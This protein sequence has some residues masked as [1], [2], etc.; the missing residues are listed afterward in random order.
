MRNLSRV[1]LAALAVVAMLTGCVRSEPIHPPRSTSTPT[2]SAEPLF[3]SDAEALAAATAAYA[4]YLKVSDEILMQGGI[5]PERIDAV[6][7]K[8]WADIQAV[9]F[10]EEHQKGWVSSGGSRYDGM[11]LQTYDSDATVGSVAVAVYV[12]VDVSAVDVRD[13][14]GVSVVSSDRPDRA[15]M[16]VSFERRNEESQDL[17]VSEEAPWSG[18]GT[19]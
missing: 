18:L 19:C 12:C 2:P 11:T 7:T 8:S 6:T 14:N 15:P 5:H 13:R 10:R 16:E 3:A 17:L 4:A 1:S 9:S